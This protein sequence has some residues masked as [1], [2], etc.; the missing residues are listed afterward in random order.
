LLKSTC[1]PP[2]RQHRS[3]PPPRAIDW[4][5]ALGPVQAPKNDKKKSFFVAKFQKKNKIKIYKKIN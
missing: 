4:A 2:Q 1:R 5:R 3:K